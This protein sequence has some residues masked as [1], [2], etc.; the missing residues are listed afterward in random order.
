MVL[1]VCTFIAHGISEVD[2]RRA[3]RRKKGVGHV[4]VAIMR[5]AVQAVDCAKY[6]LLHQLNKAALD[7]LRK[8][9]E[10]CIVQ[11]DGKRLDGQVLM[12]RHYPGLPTIFAELKW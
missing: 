4:V 5:D 9:A 10:G 3:N 8:S 12:D 11:S 6:R 2:I 7:G 1:R